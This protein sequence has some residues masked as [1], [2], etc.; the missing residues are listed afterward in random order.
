MSFL[1]TGNRINYLKEM[2]YIPYNVV[3]IGNMN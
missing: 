3:T 1:K 2:I